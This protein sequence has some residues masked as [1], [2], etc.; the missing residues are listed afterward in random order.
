MKSTPC[1]KAFNNGQAWRRTQRKTHSM[2]FSRY[3]IV[4]TGERWSNIEVK[5]S[6]LL[7]E[8]RGGER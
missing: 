5:N 2:P 4:E 7:N 8:A 3:K 6:A 1:Q